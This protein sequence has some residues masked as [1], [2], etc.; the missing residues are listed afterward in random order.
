MNSAQ[1]RGLR[2]GGG[3]PEEVVAGGIQHCHL[4]LRAYRW[5][6][7]GHMSQWSSGA[8]ASEQEAQGKGHPAAG[9]GIAPP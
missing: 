9:A 2:A 5:E 6:G 3:G 1:D 4:M 7:Q 8:P